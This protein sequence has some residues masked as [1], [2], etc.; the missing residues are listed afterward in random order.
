MKNLYF[1]P[2]L[3][4]ESW[5]IPKQLAEPKEI[6]MRFRNVFAFIA[7]AIGAASAFNPI[8]DG[9]YD[10]LPRGNLASTATFEGAGIFSSNRDYAAVPLSLAFR[11]TPKLELGAGLKTA[12]GDVG[13]HIPHAVFGAKYLIPG[14]TSLQAHLLVAMAEGAGNG[15]TLALHHRFGYSPRFYSR[16]VGKVGFMDALVNDDALMAMEGGFY[17]TLNIMRPLSLEFGLIASSQTS[18]FSENFA[19]D[20][21]PALQI[22]IGRESSVETAVALGL[23]GDRKERLRVKVAL[24]YGF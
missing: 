17:P 15:L 12:W 8:Q 10:V 11:A 3:K 20:F 2:G 13:D 21:Q 18:N 4:R 19:L 23:A 6:N 24:L 14:Q 22:H 7:F 9:G 1:R 16:L 5:V